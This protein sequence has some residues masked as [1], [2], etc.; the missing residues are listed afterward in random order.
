MYDTAAIRRIQQTERYSDCI[1][2]VIYGHHC[3]VGGAVDLNDRRQ[4][5]GRHTNSAVRARASQL[6]CSFNCICHHTNPVSHSSSPSSS[7]ESED[8]SEMVPL[9]LPASASYPT[10][11]HHHHRLQH[12]NIST[13]RKSACADCNVN[14]ERHEPEGIPPSPFFYV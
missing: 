14:D 8:E 10:I 12:T 4:T 9:P 6:D 5:T 11:I 2:R 1:Q 3:E 7:R 13:G